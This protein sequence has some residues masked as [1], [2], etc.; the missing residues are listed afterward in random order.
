M[1]SKLTSTANGTSKRWVEVETE[2]NER[3][4]KENIGR[5]PIGDVI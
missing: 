4:N 2:V 5:G 3:G 1:V